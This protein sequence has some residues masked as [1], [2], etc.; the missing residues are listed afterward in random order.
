MRLSISSS[1]E[2][3]PV[4]VRET[5]P[6]ISMMRSNKAPGENFVPPD[7]LRAFQDQWAPILAT[8]FTHID[9]SSRFPQEVVQIYKKHEH[10]NPA[11]Y[12]PISNRKTL[13]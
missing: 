6:L 1:P 8:L 10:T 3:S 12:M 7:L 2:W 4:T 9:R 5:K 13:C 11:N